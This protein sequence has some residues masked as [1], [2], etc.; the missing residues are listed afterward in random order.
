M[1]YPYWHAFFNRNVHH[2]FHAANTL[3]RTQAELNDAIKKASPGDQII[4]SKGEWKNT[5][6]LFEAKGSAGN[7]IVLLRKKRVKLYSQEIHRCV[8]RAIILW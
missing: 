6:I 2:N 1:K 3:V 4:L 7:P 8:L 5:T